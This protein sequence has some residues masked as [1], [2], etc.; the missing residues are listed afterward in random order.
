VL[1]LNGVYVTA[2]LVQGQWRRSVTNIGTRPTFGNASESSI[3]TFVIGW[4]GDLYGDVIRVRFLHRLRAERRF[5]SIEELT[6]QIRHDL[7]R[8]ANYFARAGVG[9]ELAVV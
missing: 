7:A 1:P 3:E 5:D 9:R 6:T 8:A 2:A 4:S